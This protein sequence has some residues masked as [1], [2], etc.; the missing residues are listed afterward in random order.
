MGFY[1]RGLSLTCSHHNSREQTTDQR[2]KSAMAVA[3]VA[4]LIGLN[5]VIAETA[6]AQE[7]PASLTNILKQADGS[8]LVAQ[9]MQQGDANRGKSIFH[10]EKLGCVKCHVASRASI[11]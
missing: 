10:R 9:A 1:Q 7:S 5:A 2:T 3:V 8:E 11:V 4:I 6:V